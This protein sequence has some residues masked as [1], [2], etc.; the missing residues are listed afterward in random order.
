MKLVLCIDRDNDLGS[1]AHL[2]CPII[3]REDNVNA[4]LQLGLIDPEDSDVNAIFEGIRVYDDLK[5]EGDEAEIASIAGN[6][7]VGLKSDDV[8]A[9]QLDYVL[10]KV[11]ATSV[12]IVSDGAEDEFILPIVESRIKIDGVKRVVI[13]QS[14][15]LESTYYTIKKLFEDPKIANYFFIPVGLTLILFAI[16]SFARQPEGA[17]IVISAFIGIYLL[18]RGFGLDEP[19]EG[20]ARSVKSSFYGGKISFVTYMV[21]LALG[22]IGTAQG[23]ITTLSLD[24]S[25]YGGVLLAAVF[26]NTAVW[27][28]VAAG[29]ILTIG[30]I[31]DA[32]LNDA[33]WRYVEIPF[34]I[35]STGLMLW[36]ASILIL[37]LG[38]K[39]VPV[40]TPADVLITQT[41]RSIEIVTGF[42]LLIF[43][44]AGAIIIALTGIAIS[45]L[46]KR[47]QE[48]PIAQ[49]SSTSSSDK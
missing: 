1:K 36:S 23:I 39:P 11:N 42:Q 9:K 44:V 18:F 45:S 33:K 6:E 10:K 49:L 48:P 24:F 32:Y 17:L 15:S 40:L 8:L 5:A 27:W 4:A 19:L 41:S 13:R 46:I 3:G 2:Q 20:I 47:G 34:F 38:G 26:I 16:F 29:V 30:R 37:A 21:A 28:F 35:F 25:V 12:I 43:S 14:E 22:I 7:D 31:I